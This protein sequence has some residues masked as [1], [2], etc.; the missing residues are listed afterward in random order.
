MGSINFRSNVLLYLYA[1]TMARQLD[2]ISTSDGAHKL[3]FGMNN[4]ETSN[5]NVMLWI[6]HYGKRAID[7]IQSLS[8]GYITF[9]GGDLWV[10]N[11][12]E[13]D[14]NNLFGEA[15]DS[16]L[17]VVAN[18][19]PNVVKLLDS[20]GIYTDAQW[21]V[22]SVTIP[23]TLNYPNGMYSKI[24]KERFKKREGVWQSE[25]LRNMLTTSNTLS[26]SEAISGE[27]LRGNA[28]LIRLKNNS[29]SEVKLYKVE[30]R[31][32]KGR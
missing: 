9:M 32:T 30:V 26:V 5:F 11:D 20:I 31:M 22:E 4:S 25:F 21:S 27:P 10:H 12:P 24:P 7:W 3:C 1:L 6:T 2:L 29:T 16:I 8:L 18:Q 19:E 28:A 13:Q 23:Q 17:E 15:K 14:R